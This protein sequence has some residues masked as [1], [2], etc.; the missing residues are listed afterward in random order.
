MACTLF[1]STDF[2]LLVRSIPLVDVSV[3]CVRQNDGTQLVVQ[4]RISIYI[5]SLNKLIC[6]S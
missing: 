4:L 5:C 6:A 2:R 3:V 1:A